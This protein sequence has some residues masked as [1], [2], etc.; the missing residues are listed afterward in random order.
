MFFPPL[1]QQFV[2][3]NRKK[4]ATGDHESN[5]ENS[6]L[7]SFFLIIAIQQFKYE[8]IYFSL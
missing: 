2:G 1:S 5:D 7:K 6:F 3:S 8:Q 4:P